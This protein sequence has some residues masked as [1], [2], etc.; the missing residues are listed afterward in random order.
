[1]RR[2]TGDTKQVIYVGLDL[3]LRA[4]GVVAI[5][6]ST[7]EVVHHE[8]LS[9]AVVGEERL[10]AL[11]SLL[12]STL[13]MLKCDYRIRA[14]AIEGYSM[15][16]N[17]GMLAQIAEWGGVAR[18]LLESEGT[19]FAVVAPTSLKLFATGNGQCKGKSP[20]VMA[21]YRR[22]GVEFTDDNEADACWLAH[23]ARA[24]VQSYRLKE[25]EERGVQKAY[26][27][28]TFRALF[29]SAGCVAYYNAEKS[30]GKKAKKR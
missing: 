5:K 21:L 4:S 16:S 20:V 11:S 6:G 22:H 10:C 9:C 23:M 8:V 19:P 12:A 29:R 13:Q 27:S 15:G 30:K 3:S 2:S 25:H 17:V 7:G 14:V 26:P 18:H 28:A 1:M 24:M